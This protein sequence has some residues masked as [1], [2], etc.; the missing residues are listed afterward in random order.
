M[1]PIL[2]AVQAMAPMLDGLQGKVEM[3]AW[4]PHKPI[5]DAEASPK[6]PE[7][8]LDEAEASTAELFSE[9]HDRYK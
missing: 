3:P 6:R 7:G 4:L 8:P 9:L 2:R 1:A 5:V